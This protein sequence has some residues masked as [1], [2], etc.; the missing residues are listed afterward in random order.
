M[1]RIQQNNRADKSS[2]ALV[3]LGIPMNMTH[4]YSIPDTKLHCQKIPLVRLLLNLVYSRFHLV[5]LP[6]KHSRKEID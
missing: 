5:R 4:L 6:G 2:A 1:A 3:R